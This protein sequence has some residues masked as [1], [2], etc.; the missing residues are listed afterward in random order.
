MAEI[1]CAIVGWRVQIPR[2]HIETDVT[3]TPATQGSYVGGSPGS[4]WP[5]SQ[6]MQ[7]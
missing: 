3:Q 2:T 1:V 6:R 5:A 4:W 7:W